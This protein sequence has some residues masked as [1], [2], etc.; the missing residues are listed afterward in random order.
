MFLLAVDEATRTLPDSSIVNWILVTLV[1]VMV[2]LIKRLIDSNQKAW[3]SLKL[4]NAEERKLHR[5]DIQ[6]VMIDSQ[7]NR[8]SSEKNF[9]K[10]VESLNKI[11]NKLD[12]LTFG[13]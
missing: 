10:V 13:E 7:K 8:D 11:A 12:N 9:D 5:E 2:W 1:G 3:D 6:I 4:E